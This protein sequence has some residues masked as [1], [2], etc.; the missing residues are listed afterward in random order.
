MNPN[1]IVLH[2]P[3]GVAINQWK[4]GTLH[5]RCGPD[6]YTALAEVFHQLAVQC[7]VYAQV[8]L[9]AKAAQAQA[10][11]VNPVAAIRIAEMEAEIARLRGAG[12]PVSVNTNPVLSPAQQLAAIVATREPQTVAAP[13]PTLEEVNA[14][15]TARGVQHP[16]AAAMQ[17]P[18][19]SP[20]IPPANVPPQVPPPPFVPAIDA[21]H[22]N[23]G[24]M[25]EGLPIR[26]VPILK[27][28]AEAA[29]RAGSAAPDAPGTIIS[30]GAE[31][32]DGELGPPPAIV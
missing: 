18:V 28:A 7:R 25:P 1:E 23:P 13:G 24:P 2:P 5:F 3:G 29:A 22:Q 10:A 14:A 15:I 16:A 4:G 20:I 12:I 27:L 6:S 31:M 21:T 8:A 17:Q 19:H 32:D 30:G 9:T 26:H 11:P